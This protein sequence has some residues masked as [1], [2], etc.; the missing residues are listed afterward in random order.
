MFIIRTVNPT[1]GGVITKQ[2]AFHCQTGPDITSTVF[3][4][5]VVEFAPY[6]MDMYPVIVILLVTG[7]E[8]PCVTAFRDGPPVALSLSRR[9]E[10][11]PDHR[12]TL[13]SSPT[14]VVHIGFNGA[15][16]GEAESNDI[17]SPRV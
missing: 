13:D 10:P 6:I 7:R 2:T 1:D 14:P 17:P 12:P 11:T 5:I 16:R 3:S 15:S 9:L 4:V 8:A